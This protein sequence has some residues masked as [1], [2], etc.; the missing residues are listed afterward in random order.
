MELELK[1]GNSI[2]SSLSPQA[3]NSSLIA[4]LVLCQT[5]NSQFRFVLFTLLLSTVV[6]YSPSFQGRSIF[7]QV[8]Q[9]E[10]T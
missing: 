3:I 5:M 4:Q 9:L 1:K 7:L 6:A 10:E 2:Q 8:D